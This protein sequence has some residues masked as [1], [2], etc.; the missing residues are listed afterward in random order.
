M[1]TMVLGHECRSSCCR[2]DGEKGQALSSQ[3]SWS[4]PPSGYR[5]GPPLTISP[6][7]PPKSRKRRLAPSSEDICSFSKGCRSNT[8]RAAPGSAAHS[9]KPLSMCTERL[10]GR[11]CHVQAAGKACGHRHSWHLKDHITHLQPTSS[12]IKWGLNTPRA[13]RLT[14]CHDTY[15]PSLHS[16]HQPTVRGTGPQRTCTCFQSHFQQHHN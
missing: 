7:A 16:H 8:A 15:K 5:G 1:K 6:S 9:V 11:P 14:V 3:A 2:K 10:Q 12:P 4:A 13:G